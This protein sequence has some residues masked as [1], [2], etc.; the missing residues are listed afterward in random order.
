MICN[1]LNILRLWKKLGYHN[2]NGSL[3][4]LFFGLGTSTHEVEIVAVRQV[5]DLCD[6]SRLVHLVFDLFVE[7][8]TCVSSH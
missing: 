1:L 2:Q 6:E 4:F 8:S 5:I 7:S 3:K